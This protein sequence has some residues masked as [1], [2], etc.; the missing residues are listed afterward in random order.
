MPA[1]IFAAISGKQWK[2]CT[3][4]SSSCT[5]LRVA[6]G[7]GK[8]EVCEQQVSHFRFVRMRGALRSTNLSVG[9]LCF[10]SEHPAWPDC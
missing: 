5:R 6:I 2:P 3:V 1:T 8:Q 10:C 4:R 7:A 9:P